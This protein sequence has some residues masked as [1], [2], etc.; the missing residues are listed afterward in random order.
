M[1]QS[2]MVVGL[3]FGDNSGVGLF[4]DQRSQGLTA[5]EKADAPPVRAKGIQNH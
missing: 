2:F 1:I 5:N 4:A 3:N